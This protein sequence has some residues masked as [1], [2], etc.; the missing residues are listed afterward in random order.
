MP[1]PK[2]FREPFSGEKND[3]IYG[4]TPGCPYG[5]PEVEE[6]Q[7]R[8][9]KELD[10]LFQYPPKELNVPESFKRFLIEDRNV[11]RVRRNLKNHI[12]YQAWHLTHSEIP[13]HLIE[14]IYHFERA[15]AT[16]DEAV[17]V[18][19]QTTIDAFEVGKLTHPYWQRMNGLRP[20]REELAEAI[21]KRG[22][23]VFKKDPTE[24]YRSIDIIPY[25]SMYMDEKN[26]I[27]QEVVGIT[28]RY[29]RDFGA[30]I[31]EDGTEVRFVERQTAGYRVDEASGFPQE[32][33]AVLQDPRLLGLSE[34]DCKD[35]N[36]GNKQDPRHSAFLDL[37]G[38][39]A[40]IENTVQSDLMELYVTPIETVEYGYKRN[41]RNMGRS[42]LR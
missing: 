3:P 18:G 13:T 16:I 5:I 12:H 30:G 4:A 26:I 40:F 7:D 23:E 36:W 15:T 17:E 38:C 11:G 1:L 32:N 22:G 24:P 20:M 2:Q 27:H 33:A 39:R 37:S 19:Y 10:K 28:V 6:R 41:P 8:I 35:F 9:E 25:T 14:P 31:L 21:T 29:K 42:A 34:D